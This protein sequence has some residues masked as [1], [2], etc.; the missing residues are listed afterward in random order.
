M[1][2]RFELN[3]FTVKPS[4]WAGDMLGQ[5]YLNNWMHLGGKDCLLQFMLQFPTL[6]SR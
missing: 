2:V 1:H 5:S 6:P 3:K 4:H